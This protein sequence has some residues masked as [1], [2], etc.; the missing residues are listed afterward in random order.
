MKIKGYVQGVGFRYF[1]RETAR[2]LGIVGWARNTSDGSVEVVAEG[3]EGRLAR[4]VGALRQ[5][6]PRAEVTDIEVSHEDATGEFDRFYVK[7]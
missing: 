4:F 1:T 3:N 7:T 5:G 6:P 2:E